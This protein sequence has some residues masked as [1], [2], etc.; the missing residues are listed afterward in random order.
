MG[1]ATAAILLPLFPPDGDTVQALAVIHLQTEILT[2]SDIDQLIEQAAL[3]LQ[4]AVEREVIYRTL[5][6]ERQ[7]FYERSI[8]DPLTGL[9]T[10]FYMQD[11][12]QRLFNI[13]DRDANATI[14]VIMMD[15][16]H[17]KDINDT[18]GHNRGDM[19]LQQ[20]AAV[21]LDNVRCSDLPVRLGGEEFALFVIGQPLGKMRL[22]AERLRS[23]VAELHFALPLAG[24]K[25]TL[26][27]GFAL[28]RQ[29]ESLAD[30]I[31][32]ADM[33]LYAAKR[34]GRDR[35]QIAS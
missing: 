14:A 8:R 5:D 17:F 2:S 12:V 31:Q 16:D 33:A 15:I 4:V 13:H 32:R 19:V 7:R 23:Q 26:S 22:L 34:A 21:L 25:V 28:R 18:F 3:P 1:S 24:R 10:R 35:L 6:R 9:F 11:I 20:V 29:Q 27:A 30:F